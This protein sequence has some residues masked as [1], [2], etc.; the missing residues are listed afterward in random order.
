MD[1]H[2]LPTLWLGLL[3][4]GQHALGGADHFAGV[5]PFAARSGARAW[6]VG[7]AWGV[8]H[9]S[10]AACA[11]ILALALRAWIPGVEAELSNSSDRIVG[12]LMCLVGA[13]GLRAALKASVH[14][15]VHE[16]A[17][18]AHAHAHVRP[19]A[20]FS[21]WNSS[22]GD[23]HE[24]KHSAFVLGLFHGAGGLAHLFAVVPALGFPGVAL[25][26]LYLAGYGIGSLALITV[27]A[28]GIGRIAPD[29]KPRLQRRALLVASGCSVAVGLVWI[30]HPA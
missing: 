18:V 3:A 13:L 14:D 23:Q 10:G 21:W 4:G 11:A 20:L 28:A 1:W 17:G 24:H 2:A 15:H 6:R 27:F 5:A 8:G 12:V 9:A 16:H 7:L 29:S 19:L 22:R 30:V 26:A 25:P